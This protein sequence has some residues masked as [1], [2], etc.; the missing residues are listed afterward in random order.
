MIRRIEC[1][2]CHNKHPGVHPEDKKMGFK[3]RALFISTQKPENHGISVNGVFS[4]LPDVVCDSCDKV[5]TAHVAVATTQWRESQEGE[6]LEWE[7][8]YGKILTPDDV[9]AIAALEGREAAK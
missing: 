1:V 6:P 8:E 5:V 2:E 9:K 4:P 7:S 3:K